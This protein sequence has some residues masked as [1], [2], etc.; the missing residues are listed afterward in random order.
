[1]LVEQSLMQYL[2][3][4]GEFTFEA[5]IETANNE[6]L[7]KMINFDEGYSFVYG[8][9]VIVNIDDVKKKAAGK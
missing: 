3:P 1:M 8:H 4:V 6:I 5:D 2:K 9:Q 7:E